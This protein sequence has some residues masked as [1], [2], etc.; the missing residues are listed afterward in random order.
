MQRITMI[1]SERADYRAFG[2]VV[3]AIGML[4]SI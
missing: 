1:S 2:A 3:I 4:L